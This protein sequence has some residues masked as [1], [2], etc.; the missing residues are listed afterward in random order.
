MRIGAQ[1]NNL[2]YTFSTLA[3]QA[4]VLGKVDGIGSG[5]RFWSTWGVAV[6]SAGTV[7]VADG[8]IRKITPEGIVSTPAD[9]AVRLLGVAVD[10]AGN[11][12][13]VDYNSTIR[14]ITPN[15]V[16]TTLAGRA[17]VTGS[18][19]GPGSVARFNNP[20]GVAVDG[21]GNVYVADWANHTIRKITPAGEVSTLA[22]LAGVS[23]GSDGT[24]NVARFNFPWGV[25]VDGSGY[26]YVGDYRNHTIRKISPDGQTSTLAGS[27]MAPGSNDGLGNAARFVNPSGVAVDGRGNVYVADYNNSTLRKITPEGMVSTLG[28]KP[29]LSGSEDG[30]GSMARFNKPQGVAVDGAGNLYVADTQNHTIRVG[31]RFSID[32][33]TLR[34]SGPTA[35]LNVITYGNNLFVAVGD[36]ILTSTDGVDW[37]TRASG[38]TTPL[39][40]ITW[41]KD[42]YVA[43]GLFGVILTSPDGVNWTHRDSG[44]EDQL[45]CVTYGHDLFVVGGDETILTSPD[46]IVWTSH[47]LNLSIGPCIYYDHRLNDLVYGDNQFLAVGMFET[48]LT[49]PDGITWTCKN[50]A[51]DFNFRSVAYGKQTYVV[52]G[53]YVAMSSTNGLSWSRTNFLDMRSVAYGANRFVAVSAKNIFSSADGLNWKSHNATVTNQLSSVAYGNHTFVAVGD[54]VIVQSSPLGASYASPVLNGRQVRDGFELVITGTTGQAYSLQSASDL[55]GNIFWQTRTNVTLTNSEHIWRD[56]TVTN[57][58]RRFYRSIVLP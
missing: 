25:A 31:S 46:G 21:A 19:D 12:Y 35:Y 2:T 58:V 9:N 42:L 33:W 57:G 7:Y 40:D 5:A 48:M 44:T 38:I 15:G 37:S 30:P 14:K 3:G 47:A 4:G 50:P 49:S 53:S 51:Y 18:A 28:G 56:D 45:N 24:G 22:G 1:T 27:A 39:Y 54:R 17:E 6:D 10:S 41:G 43:V 29:G 8:N 20:Q 13:A 16:V 32:P 11:I 36:Q 55:S 23:G 34:H 26:V 52:V